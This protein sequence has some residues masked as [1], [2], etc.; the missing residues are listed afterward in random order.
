MDALLLV[1]GLKTVTGSATL[2]V[3]TGHACFLLAPLDINHE[4]RWLA[5]EGMSR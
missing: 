1:T 4:I 3:T 2:V 5:V